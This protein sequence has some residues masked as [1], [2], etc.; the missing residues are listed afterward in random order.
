[1][2]PTPDE[3]WYG[4]F[5]RDQVDD[6][7]DLGVEV[8][9][10]DIDG[11]RDWRNYLRAARE[12][13][14][15]VR[16]EP[17]DLVHAH[18]GLTGAVAAAQR[19]LPTVTTFHGSDYTGAVP[20]Q[21]YVSFVVARTS[22][23]IVVSGEGRRTLH[24]RSAAVIPAGVDTELFRP[25]DRRAARRE[26]GWDER[27]PYFLLPGRRASRAKRADL[28]DAVVREARRSVATLAGVSL[29]GFSRR[30]VALALNAA[31]VTVVTSDREGSP[32]AVRE[33]LACETPVVSVAVG[34]VPDV[35][36][37]LPGCAVCTR[38]PAA[39]A[40][41]ALVA[42]ESPRSPELRERAELSSRRRVV[43]QVT[44][45][46]ERVLAGEARG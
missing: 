40:A 4:S 46:Y 16:E 8:R 25:V 34:D 27:G 37:G 7:R 5:V 13:R 33:S 3:P 45:L 1:M 18:Y 41:A 9:V 32:V 26:L 14:R 20:W 12:V 24:L 44:A 21:R 31:D 35:V 22:V 10:L 43:E 11:R 39:L 36:R 30:E 15:I 6:L 19:R 29:E 23:P 38:D 28:F 17:F 2:Y 42:L